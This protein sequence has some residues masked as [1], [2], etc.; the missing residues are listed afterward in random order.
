MAIVGVFVL[1]TPRNVA[2]G[3]FREAG[4]AHAGTFGISVH[5]DWQN[6]GEDLFHDNHKA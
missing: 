5:D 4:R 2:S 1:L 6:Q 3:V